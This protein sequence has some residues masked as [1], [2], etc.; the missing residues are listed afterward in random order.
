MGIACV[1][2]VEECCGVGGVSVLKACLFV[3]R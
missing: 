1:V 2:D 3:V